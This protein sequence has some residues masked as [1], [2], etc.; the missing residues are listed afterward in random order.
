MK[1]SSADTNTTF[2]RGTV[3]PYWG[4]RRVKVITHREV[5]RWVS[6]MGY[7]LSWM[8]NCH[9][10]LCQILDVAVKD[11]RVKKNV[12]R[13]VRL[14]RKVKTVHVHL[15]MQQLKDF[16]DEC[17]RHGEIVMLLGSSGLR[18]GELAA[19]RR[20]TWTR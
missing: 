15:T 14:P 19:L 17:T 4:E 7:S 3:K 2:W 18:W 8:R 11:Q 5:Q 13:G 16:A 12:A 20:G 6:G 10:V 9:S 1:P